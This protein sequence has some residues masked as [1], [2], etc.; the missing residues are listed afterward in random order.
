MKNFIVF[1]LVVFS[2]ALMNGCGSSPGGSA[3]GSGITDL[4]ALPK[5]TGPV[6]GGS[7]I[8]RFNSGLRTD[9]FSAT[10]GK[11]LDDWGSVT[12]NSTKSGPLCQTGNMFRNLLQ[13]AAQP[14][15]IMCYVG[16][17]E[18]NGLFTA[19]Y[20]GTYKYYTFSAPGEGRPGSTM[21]IKFKMAKASDGSINAFEMFNCEGDVNT[22]TE[23]IGQTIS[24]TTVTLTNVGVHTSGGTFRQRTTVTGEATSTGWTSKTIDSAGSFVVSSGQ[25]YSMSQAL[26]LVQYSNRAQLSGYFTGSFGQNSHTGRIF[27]ISQILTPDTL[28]TFAMGD[29]TLKARF[30]FSGGGYES[31]SDDVRGWTGD[32]TA[33]KS[34]VANAEYYSDVN[35]GTL[36]TVGTPNTAFA[37]SETWN[38]QPDGSFQTIAMDQSAVA[39]MTGINNCN[40][41]Y[42]YANQGG[43]VDCNSANYSTY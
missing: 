5:A 18:T 28:K 9:L 34:P 10:T 26:T 21:K 35:A 38:C 33:P 7:S 16:V 12:W 11:K 36:P 42:E 27:S 25:S 30:A 23:Y 29:G 39:V 8:N 13:Q 14:D 40:N 6:V 24:G 41:V 43:W 22:N 15:K 20:D 4:S 1:A 32:D 37:A 17:M 31:S 19:S 3:T 2:I